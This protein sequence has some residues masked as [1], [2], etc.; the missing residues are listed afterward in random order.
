M[1]KSIVVTLI[2]P[3]R[4][5]LVNAISDKAVAFG[6]NWGDSLMA[7]LAGQFAGIVH[8]QVPAKNAEA[9]MA[10][11]RTLDTPTMRVA[12]AM[13]SDAADSVPMRRLKLDLVGQDRPGIINSI[14]SQLAAHGISIATLQTQI[15]SGA[16][17]GEQMFQM[18]ASLQVPTTLSDQTLRDGLEGL[19]NELMV[20]IELDESHD[21]N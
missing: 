16:M 10:A 7:N 21:A 13:G 6:A 2:G 4:P 12:V 17:S 5:G 20:D 19:A 15:T 14:S 18:H 8:L 9:L 11:L 1:M 3:D